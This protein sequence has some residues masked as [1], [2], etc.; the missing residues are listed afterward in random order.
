MCLTNLRGVVPL[1]GLFAAG[2][3]GFTDPLLAVEQ[4]A[5]DAAPTIVRT[6]RSGRWS[7]ASTWEGGRLPA[8]GARVQIRTGH[9]VTYDLKSAQVIRSVHVAGT[10]TFAR[11]R[12]TRLDVGL[13]KIQA[14]DDASEDGFDCDAHANELAP[15]MPRPALEVG[16]AQ[17]PIPAQ[18]TALI[19]LTYVSGLDK[20]SCPAIVC[21][22]GRMDFHGSP[23]SRSW[24][25]LGATAKKKDK[26]VTLA[27]PVNG[28]KV[29]DRIIITATG[30]A[31]TSGNGH[32]GPDPQ[33]TT[34]EER[35]IQAIGG[36]RITLNEP[37]VH[38][39]LGAGLYRGEIANLSRNVVVESAD[40]KLRGHTMYHKHSA[41]A[42]S[43]A[44]F[45][46]LGKEGI[47]GR[48]ALH[49]HLCGD[50]MR[51]SYVIGASIWDSDNRWLVIH[52]TNY[53][54][55]RDNVGYRSKGHGFYLEDGTEVY[56]VLDRNL[57]VGA[58]PAKPLP[59]QLLAFDANDGAGFW[60]ANS[61]NTFTRNV[62]TENGQYGFRYEAM[63]ALVLPIR[64]PDGSQKK[65]DIRTLPF[66]RFDDNEGHSQTGPYE[67]KLGTSGEKDGVGPDEKHPFIIRNLLVWS[68]HYAF[69]TRMPSVLIDG[70]RQHNTV[71]GFR[72]MNCDNHVYR[73]ITISGRANTAFAAISAGPK[74]STEPNHSVIFD[75]GGK[76]GGK[77]RLTVDGLT[78][79]GIY[80]GGPLINIFDIAAV[81]KVAHFRN[82]KHDDRLGRS[83]RELL[84]V[85]PVVAAPPKTPQDVAPVYLHDY[86]GKG[87]HAKAVWIHAKHY[88]DDGLMYHDEKLLTGNQYGMRTVV[89]E[90]RD[91]E[92]P[93]LL[94]PVDDLPPTTVITHVSKAPGGKVTVRGATADNGTVKRVLVNGREA[95]AT[96]ANFAEWEIIVDNA[97]KLEAHAEDAAGNVEK[98]PH[99]VVRAQAPKRTANQ[100]PTEAD[101][102]KLIERLIELDSIDLAPK[103]RFRAGL[104]PSLH[105][106]DEDESGMIA[107]KDPYA[108]HGQDKPGAAGWYRLSFVVPEK[109]GKFAMPK[110]G[111]NLGIESNVLGSWEIYTYKNGKPA[112]LWSKDGMNKA[113][114]RPATDW[115]SNAPQPAL[116]GDK[117]TVAILAMAS[118]LGRG[119]P[120]GFALRHLRLRFAWGHT[121]ARQP[122]YGGVHA[123]GQGNGLLGAREKLRTLK[124]DELTALQEKLRSP[125]ARLEAVFAAAE[126]GR[127]ENLT[128]AMLIASKEINEALKK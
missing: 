50:T 68:S 39:H 90:V 31:P 30:I 44:E 78:F 100:G 105:T 53:L 5:K 18:H 76:L 26:V 93:K 27:D 15:G 33:G 87:R 110:S 86:Y 14:G 122:F 125:I 72:A 107:L 80:G 104:E 74:P 124:G 75:G 99:L 82:V 85:S 34:S 96:A 40:R 52:G 60:W 56:N 42:I 65:V 102:T 25:R 7:A 114:D 115:M 57:A 61:L 6:A 51:G 109:I 118:P 35:T 45:R 46:H 83:T 9:T 119:S 58:R 108:I 121:A 38:E 92:F 49:Y 59:K 103:V 16:T 21:C 19:R 29:G 13:I 63:A 67:V 22:G 20:Q 41:G 70:L 84:H 43:H 1:I 112:G 88:A 54:V 36:A 8:A 2:A 117:F 91:I 3:G 128:K 32:P 48:Y 4:S 64:Q 24:V 62:A 73:N 55:V 71:Y 94:D 23:L 17:Q 116:P 89:A 69:D 12:D 28:W 95:K 127:L 79:E 66:V 101:L 120:E 37:L 11:D 106:L 77:L 113:A 98:T 47:L 10:L 123:P 97:G 111:F 81:S 126:T